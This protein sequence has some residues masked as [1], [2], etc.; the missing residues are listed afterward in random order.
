MTGNLMTGH[1]LCKCRLVRC[2]GVSVGVGAAETE[3]TAARERVRTWWLSWQQGSLPG[4]D[5]RLGHS[6]K[7]SLGVRVR[8][9]VKDGLCRASLD[10]GTEIHHGD[11]VTHQ[12]N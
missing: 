7:Q 5:F 6:S 2:A 8:W 12:A 1:G 11:P 9:G 10:D 3:A 4:P